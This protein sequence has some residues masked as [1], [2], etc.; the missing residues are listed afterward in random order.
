MS[1]HAI[2]IAQRGRHIFMN[3]H[4]RAIRSV[5][6]RASSRH[7]LGCIPGNVTPTSHA[8]RRAFRRVLRELAILYYR[9]LWRYGINRRISSCKG[10][11]NHNS[12]QS[13]AGGRPS[14]TSGGLETDDI[15]WKLSLSGDRYIYMP[16][17]TLQAH[18]VPPF[19]KSPSLQDG[20]AN[21]EGILNLFGMFADRNG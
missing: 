11:G 7:S 16:Q 13:F 6:V 19:R 18:C 8:V 4:G 9:V 20:R 3:C 10:P 17:C 1:T 21:V 15:D 14:A 2:G 12:E 5:V